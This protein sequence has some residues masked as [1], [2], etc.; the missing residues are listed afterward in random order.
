[1]TFAAGPSRP[2]AREQHSPLIAVGWHVYKH[3]QDWRTFE[4][5][6]ILQLLSVRTLSK[7]LLQSLKSFRAQRILAGWASGGDGP[8]GAFSGGGGGSVSGSYERFVVS[9]PCGIRDTGQHAHMDGS[10]QIRREG[11]LAR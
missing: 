4:D 1:V 11:D 9:T 3:S 2:A 8:R 7:T 6:T 10:R 5:V